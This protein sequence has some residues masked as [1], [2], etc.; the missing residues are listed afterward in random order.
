VLEPGGSLLITTHGVFWDHACPHDYWRWTA[1][2]LRRALTKAGFEVKLLLKTTTNE[3][4][5]L[6]LLEKELGKPL[7][8]AGG[9]GRLYAASSYLFRRMSPRLRHLMA[10]KCFP[11]RSV[12]DATDER[13]ESLYPLYIIVGAVAVKPGLSPQSESHS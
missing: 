3:R 4:A 8:N 9:L 13:S 7:P 11:D 5:V 10:D 1:H 6:Y 12:V 2:G